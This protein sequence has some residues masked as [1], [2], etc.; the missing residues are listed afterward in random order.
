[1]FIFIFESH[2]LNE[3]IL[4]LYLS[5]VDPLFKPL[6]VAEAIILDEEF[7]EAASIF[8]VVIEAFNCFFLLS[9]L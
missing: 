1:M 2:F 9:F 6:N 8:L 5:A 7:W 3:F 4:W